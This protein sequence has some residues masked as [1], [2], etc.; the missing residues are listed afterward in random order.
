MDII[1]KF[2]YCYIRFMFCNIQKNFI[3]LIYF[4]YTIINYVMY[5]LPVYNYVYFYC[6]FIYL[7]LTWA[8]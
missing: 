8:T 2:K 3:N 5:K 4:N 6:I 1:G 7:F